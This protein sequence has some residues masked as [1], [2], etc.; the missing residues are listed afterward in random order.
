MENCN[1]LYVLCLEF[2]QF[3]PRVGDNTTLGIRFTESSDL[4]VDS[5]VD[6]PTPIVIYGRKHFSA[7]VIPGQLIG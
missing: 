2:L 6:L 3:G 5:I 4:I 7:K 1:Q